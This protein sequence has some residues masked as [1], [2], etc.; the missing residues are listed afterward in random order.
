MCR[1]GI[2]AFAVGILY[3]TLAGADETYGKFVDL[4]IALENVPNGQGKPFRLL[5][6]L[7]FEDP[8]GTVWSVP[9]GGYTDGASIP[10]LFQIIVGDNYSG[11][12]FPAAVI[13]D[14]YCCVQSHLAVDTHRSFYYGM[15][16]NGTPE[17]Q[18]WLMYTAVRVAGPDWSDAQVV[19]NAD[20]SQCLDDIQQVPMAMQSSPTITFE[21]GPTMAMRRSAPNPMGEFVAA[22]SRAQEERDT[23]ILSK[24]M[25]VAK[26]L[27]ESEGKVIDVTGLGQI[28]ATFEGVEQLRSIV[29]RATNFADFNTDVNRTQFDDFGLLV[30]IEGSLTEQAKTLSDQGGLSNVSRPWTASELNR[31][32]VVSERLPQRLPQS[33]LQDAARDTSLSGTGLEWSVARTPQVRQQWDRIIDADRNFR[34]WN[35][36]R[37]VPEIQR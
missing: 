29:S 15:L 13:H 27:K 3:P 20:G 36:M 6:E 8:N 26:T 14:F 10:W 16:A 12:Y 4:P 23:F 34:N 37:A 7:K 21:T 5:R 35:N 19:A 31:L 33:Y 1:L 28:P 18:A 9:S 24:L 22:A 25:A 30:P 2:A 17:W 11:P 32:G